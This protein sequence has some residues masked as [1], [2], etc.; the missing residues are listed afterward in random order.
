M[1]MIHI[2]KRIIRNTKKNVYLK[3]KCQEE[4]IKFVAE[5]FRAEA[6][7]LSRKDAYFL[8]I[9]CINLILYL[10]TFTYIQ[11]LQLH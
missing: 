6:H 4:R 8:I 1:V 3:E 5:Q 7:V 11:S 2:V 10:M 9:L